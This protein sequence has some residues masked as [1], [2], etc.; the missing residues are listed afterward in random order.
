MPKS[1]RS[2]A[3][4]VAGAVRVRDAVLDGEIVHLDGDGRPRFYSLLRRLAPQQFVAFDL[5]WLNGE[6]L[7]QQSLVERKRIL[8]SVVPPGAAR[9]STLTTFLAGRAL[10]R[11]VCE[12][13]PERIVA[14]RK[15]GLN[16]PE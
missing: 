4:A 1:A 13:A 8:R 10:F 16:T 15:D 6:D 5:L 9:C 12:A 7:R 14:K 11:A 2:S 3:A